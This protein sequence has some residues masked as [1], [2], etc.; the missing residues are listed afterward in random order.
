MNT[1][2]KT[3][4]LAPSWEGVAKIHLM[5][6][7]NGTD[8]GKADARKGII[9]MGKLLD[10]LV[11]EREGDSDRCIVQSEIDGR[12]CIKE[13]GHLLAHQWEAKS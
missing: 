3:I 6:L 2:P 13:R 8:E 7:E 10:Q 1:K 9:E 4:N 5:L 11:A 12:R